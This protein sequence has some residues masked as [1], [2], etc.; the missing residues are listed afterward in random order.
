[1]SIRRSSILVLGASA[2]V[3]AAVTG[4]AFAAWIEHGANMFLAM[5]ENGLS[6]CF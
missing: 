6:W 5:A 3:L 1:M 4:A 2:G